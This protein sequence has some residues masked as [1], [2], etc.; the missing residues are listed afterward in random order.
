M[1]QQKA[2]KQISEHFFVGHG[3]DCYSIGLAPHNNF[4]VMM[5]TTGLIG[6]LIYYLFVFKVFR[7]AHEN[8][9]QGDNISFVCAV[10]LMGFMIQLGAESFLVGNNIIVLMPYFFMGV[11]IYRNRSIKYEKIRTVE[12][13]D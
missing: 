13:M 2:L 8:F 1:L 6:V 12:N 11:I 7:M 9:C 4:L 3:Y 10:I 5:F